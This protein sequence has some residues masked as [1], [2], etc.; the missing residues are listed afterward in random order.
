MDLAI[1][2]YDKTGKATV[3]DMFGVQDDDITIEIGNSGMR[4]FGSALFDPTDPTPKL[5]RVVIGVSTVQWRD[6]ITLY[7]EYESLEPA[8]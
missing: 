8:E 6:A 3:L 4:I 2:T 7:P 5:M 1:T